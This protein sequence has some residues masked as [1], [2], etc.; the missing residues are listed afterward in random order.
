MITYHVEHQINSYVGPV[1][2]C[3]SRRFDMLEY[4]D[5]RYP[6]LGYTVFVIYMRWFL[7]PMALYTWANLNH[8]LCG[9]S[10]DPFYVI[11]DTG[12]CYWPL[13]ELYL[14]L[15]VVVVFIGNF[16]ICYIVKRVICGDKSRALTD[17]SVVGESNKTK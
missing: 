10:S 12:K 13:A 9:T 4:M 8:T 16:V 15:I 14:G 17:E 3:L 2:L 5:W 7:S 1:I 11:F 6:M